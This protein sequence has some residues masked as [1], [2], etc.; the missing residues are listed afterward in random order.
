MRISLVRHGETHENAERIIQGQRYGTLSKKGKEQVEKLTERLRNESFDV[1]ISSD[2]ERTRETTE[3]IA[4]FHDTPVIFSSL[5]RERAFGDFE[6]RKLDDYNKFLG[7][8]GFSRLSYKPEGGEN[9]IELR[10]RAREFLRDLKKNH[11]SGDDVL[12]VSHGGFIRMV[13]GEVLNRN[14]EDTLKISMENTCVNVLDMNGSE[15]KVTMMN[16]YSHIV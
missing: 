3:Y 1:I 9:F 14:M 10:E 5:I 12:V 4:R 8:N 13:L 6:G 2:S 7:K 15:A 11:D 16:E